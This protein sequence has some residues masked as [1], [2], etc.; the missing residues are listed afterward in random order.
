MNNEATYVEF[1]R[2]LESEPAQDGMWDASNCGYGLHM[3]RPAKE[4][5]GII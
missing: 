5:K 2:P 3:M 4:A 1:A